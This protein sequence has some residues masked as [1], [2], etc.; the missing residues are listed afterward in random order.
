[1]TDGEGHASYYRIDAECEAD[2]PLSKKLIQTARRAEDKMESRNQARILASNPIEEY[3]GMGT[4][5]TMETEQDTGEHKRQ[6]KDEKRSCV[7]WH[8]HSPAE[9]GL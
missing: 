7:P 9:V 6:E 4:I 8:E 2:I 1:M 5:C 3:N